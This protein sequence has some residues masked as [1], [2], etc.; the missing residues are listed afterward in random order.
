MSLIRGPLRIAV[1]ELA[2]VSQSLSY[3]KGPYAGSNDGDSGK[4]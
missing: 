3:P 1:E 4:I 2:I